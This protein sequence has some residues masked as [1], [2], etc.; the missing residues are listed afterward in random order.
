LHVRIGSTDIILRRTE[1]SRI[2]IKTA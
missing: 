1:A 2:Q